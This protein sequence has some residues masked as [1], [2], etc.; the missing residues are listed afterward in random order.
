[1]GPGDRLPSRARARTR[2]AFVWVRVD[3]AEMARRLRANRSA[4]TRHDVADSVLTWFL[5][6][7]E[8]PDGAEG[9]V[10]L[11]SDDRLIDQ[12]TA[13][14]ADR[15]NDPQLAHGPGK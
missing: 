11:L 10:Q 2:S 3:R 13:L 9:A 15:F 5:A 4:P 12:V 7:F 14:I 6:D 8:A 1:M